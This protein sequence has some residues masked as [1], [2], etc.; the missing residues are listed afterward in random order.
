MGLSSSSTSVG[1]EVQKF[2]G[3]VGLLA[4]GLG[5]DR[6]GPKSTNQSL[7]IARAMASMGLVHP[8][9]E[10][11]FVV[12]GAEHSYDFVFFTFPEPIPPH[13]RDHPESLQGGNAVSSRTRRK[14]AGLAPLQCLG[15]F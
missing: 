4:F 8:P 3:E 5:P 2:L 13:P 12:E 1:K 15:G 7:K 6:T 14:T 9:V 11:D 10:V